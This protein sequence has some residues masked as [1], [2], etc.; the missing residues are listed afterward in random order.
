MNDY[1]PSLAPPG[2]GLPALE[3]RLVRIAF[4]AV[5]RLFGHQALSDRLRAETAKV[6]ALA[7]RL[8]PEQL[9][10]P[11]LVPRLAGLEDSSRYW[12]AAM[13]VQHLVI[14]GG[15]IGGLVGALSRQQQFGREVRIADVKPAPEAGEEQLPLLAGTVDAYLAQ[16][17]AI[18]DL[19]T[20]GRHAHPWFGPLDSH[21]W[22]A[23]AAVHTAIHR[24]QLEAILRALPK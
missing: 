19:R 20:P 22:H 12:S 4:A 24:R 10:Q 8:T 5:R 17:A 9:R 23:L 13:V 18:A 15:G 21:G 1:R 2:T 11:V 7:G 16:V 14:V 3:L 6:Q